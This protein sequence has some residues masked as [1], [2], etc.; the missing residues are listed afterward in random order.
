M[1]TGS[2]DKVTP[3]LDINTIKYTTAYEL[4]SFERSF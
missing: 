1:Y 2:H 4:I 3:T